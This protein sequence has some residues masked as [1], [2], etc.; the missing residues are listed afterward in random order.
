MQFNPEL[1]PVRDY[2][3]VASSSLGI[4]AREYEVTQLVQLLQTMSPESPMYPLLIESIVENMNLSNREQI[5]ESLRQ[6]N[7]PKPEQQ[8]AQMQ[9]MQL[10]MA[11]KQATVQNIQAQ[12]QEI[13]SRVQQNAV[14]TELLPIETMGKITD[15]EE[16][17]FQRR[18]ELAK[19]LLKERDIEANNEIVKAQMRQTNGN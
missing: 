2:K 5:I 12:T 9:A 17:D 16:M 10:E 8:Q 11:Q 3:F 19:L 15:P 6:A 13:M 4:I 1:Y 14:E 18:V 7:Q